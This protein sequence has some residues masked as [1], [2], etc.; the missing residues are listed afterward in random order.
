MK[1]NQVPKKDIDRLVEIHR[2]DVPNVHAEI[3]ALKKKLDEL[4][5][6]REN[7]EKPILNIGVDRKNEITAWEA[8]N[9]CLVEVRGGEKRVYLVDKEP[10]V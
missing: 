9:G 5:V 3:I 4:R 7:L 6:E 1:R 10:F 8:S 2:V